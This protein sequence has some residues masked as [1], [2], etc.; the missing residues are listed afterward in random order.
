[1]ARKKRQPVATTTIN[2]TATNTNNKMTHT[3]NIPEDKTD[4]KSVQLHANNNDPDADKENRPNNSIN[5]N[6]KEEH[7]T[8]NTDSTATNI[9][10]ADCKQG[11]SNNT[12]EENTTTN[13]NMTQTETSAAGSKRADSNETNATP[14]SLARKRN[15]RST[16]MM[17]SARSKKKK[18]SPMAADAAMQVEGTAFRDDIIGI[19]HLR[20][21]GED[22]FNLTL[23]N[24]VVNDELTDKG[25]SAFVTLRDVTSGKN[26]EPLRGAEGYPQSMFLSMDRHSF[27]NA[28]DAQIAVQKQ[29]D[30]IRSIASNPMHNIYGYKY[31]PV[32]PLSN[33]TGDNLA[34]LS[35]LVRYSDA[36]RILKYS[37]GDPTYQ[38]TLEPNF[39][40]NNP[41]I[42]DNYFRNVDEIPDHIHEELGL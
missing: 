30:I 25:F 14:T 11:E 3:K 20:S 28:K 38:H 22:A 5:N 15:G 40:I 32:T 26:D 16:N 18:K 6:S 24:M 41:D 23:K 19:R 35:D 4:S 27:E 2:N 10:S 1:M 29:C 36:F 33:K 9:S 37:Y 42:I 34:V 21:D 7:N 17:S 39:A 31:D 12:T 8:T 13:T